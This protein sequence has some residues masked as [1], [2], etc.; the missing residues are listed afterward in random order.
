MGTT[1]LGLRYPDSTNAVNVPADIQNLAQDVDAKFVINNQFVTRKD[2]VQAV[3]SNSPSSAIGTSATAVLT[4]PN[5]L[6]QQGRAYSLEVIGG[7]YGDVDGRLCD[8]SVFKT[9]VAGTQYAAFY[10]KR[11]STVGKQVDAYSQVYVK[12]TGADLTTDIVLSIA[13]DAGTVTM[14]AGAGSRPRA[15][16]VRDVG[17]AAQYAYCFDVT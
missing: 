6:F 4:L 5:C 8:I 9:S 15:L 1:S 12:H 2:G 16:V 13:A 10:R 7:L 17:T 14:D 3:A 11:C